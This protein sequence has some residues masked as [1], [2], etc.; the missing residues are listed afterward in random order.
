LIGGSLFVIMMVPATNCCRKSFFEQEE[1]LWYSFV[2][3]EEHFGGKRFAAKPNAE[4][5]RTD[6]IRY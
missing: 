4:T 1:E 3:I 5:I 6:N 2:Y